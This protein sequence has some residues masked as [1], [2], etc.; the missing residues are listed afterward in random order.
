M[1]THIARTWP[2]LAHEAE[3]WQSGHHLVAGLDEVGRG[4]WAGPV[5]AAA[6]VLPADPRALAPLLGQVDDSKRLSPA[7]RERL[8]VQIRARALAVGIGSVPAPEIDGAGILNATRRAMIAAIAALAVPPDALLIDY[9][10]LA[11]VR[12]PQRGIPHGDALSLSI[13]AA[14]VVAKVWRDAWMAAQEDAFPGYRFSAHKGYGTH[15]HQ[16]ALG[17]LGPCP[18]HRRT[19]RPVA[20]VCGMCPDEGAPA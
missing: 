11:T 5:V 2:D 7:A 15:A 19:F 9:L 16:V 17:R 18:L 1:P 12:L 3:F 4:A 13:A 6:V 10:T 8:A 14:S 20:A